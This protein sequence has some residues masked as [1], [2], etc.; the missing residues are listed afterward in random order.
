MSILNFI[1]THIVNDLEHVFC[2]YVPD[3]QQILLNEV[4]DLIKRLS[5]WVESKN[6]I[7]GE[8]SDEEKK[9]S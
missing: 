7:K 6:T 2:S 1:I 3:M 9:G 8:S 4:T 5:D